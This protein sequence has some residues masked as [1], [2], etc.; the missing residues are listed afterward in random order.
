MAKRL[1]KWTASK[2]VLTAEHLELNNEKQT[3]DLHLLYP[4]YDEWNK[5]QQGVAK[6]GVKQRL[7]DKT[8]DSQGTK[9][10]P[11]ER[12]DSMAEFWT[13]LTVEGIYTKAA[14]SQGP[15]ASLKPIVKNALDK[16]WSA[17][18]IAEFVGKPVGIIQ[19]IVD[20]LNA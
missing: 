5:A 19:G 17:K 3:F 2:G 20:E 10:T 8:T 1:V 13:M 4:E 18:D 14:V 7:V 9:L 11:A 12:R 16:G 6:N 15:S